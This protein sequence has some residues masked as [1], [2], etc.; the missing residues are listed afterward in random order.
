MRIKK[1]SVN[2]SPVKLW[3]FSPLHP[4]IVSHR[5]PLGLRWKNSKNS[6]STSAHC[7]IDRTRIVE[8]VF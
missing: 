4:G 8:V 5:W 2:H 3:K 1:M 6:T 7:G